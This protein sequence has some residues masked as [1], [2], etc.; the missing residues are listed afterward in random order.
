LISSYVFIYYR[1]KEKRL[2]VAANVVEMY[3]DCFPGS[4]KKNESEASS[5]DLSEQ[6]QQ[7]VEELYPKWHQLQHFINESK[8]IHL[9]SFRQ[10][11]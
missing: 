10:N 11:N 2:Q 6:K 1:L 7:Q 3:Y 8:S 4:I 5:M 9:E